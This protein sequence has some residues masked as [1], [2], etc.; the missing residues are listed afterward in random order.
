[1]TAKTNISISCLILCVLMFSGY[2]IVRY[3][4]DYHELSTTVSESTII[5]LTTSTTANK[6]NADLKTKKMLSTTAA[7]S[8]DL[9]SETTQYIVTSIHTTQET[10]SKNQNKEPDT[11]KATTIPQTTANLTVS[12]APY[13]LTSFDEE[14]IDLVNAER[15]KAGLTSLTVSSDICS[16]AAIRA[17]EAS[18]LWSHTRPM[19]GKCDS[20]FDEYNVEWTLVGENLAHS[21][22][23]N[24]EKI[25]GAW[26]NSESHRANIL[27]A[28]FAIC[29]IATY[30]N[31]NGDFYVAQIFSK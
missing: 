5:K 13:S 16:I 6:N 14:L 2:N 15:N 26:M 27:N 10:T 1:M 28:S 29:G 18:S 7:T 24:A 9:V 11:T 25:V 20:L 3:K 21:S 30:T 17:E 31:V 19:G 4:N 8:S 12:L 23:Y 22:S